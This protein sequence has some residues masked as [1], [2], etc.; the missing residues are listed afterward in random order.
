M[1]CDA[2]D[3]ALGTT[4]ID[5]GGV[6]CKNVFGAMLGGSEPGNYFCPANSGVGAL[7]AIDFA[8][9]GPVEI[10]GVRFYAQHDN[11]P[12]S[13]RATDLFEF[14]ADL[15]DDSDFLDPREA[16]ISKSIAI[17]YST[18]PDNANPGPNGNHLDLTFLVSATGTRWRMRVRWPDGLTGAGIDGPRIL[19]LD[20]MAV[21]YFEKSGVDANG[22]ELRPCEMVTYTIQANNTAGSSVL[23]SLQDDLPLETT[24]LCDRFL[25]VARCVP[26]F[27][28]ALFTVAEGPL[29]AD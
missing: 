12:G 7:C 26:P 6:N 23:F 3:T 25:E 5:C 28:F 29:N 9:P 27:L 15:N 8:T 13:R 21:P 10:I 11:N 22:D 14:F 4:V 16:L 1:T 2:F 20:A 24:S 19:E 17:P 18:E